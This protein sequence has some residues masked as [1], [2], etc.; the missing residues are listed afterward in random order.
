MASIAEALR[1]AAVTARE[2][3]IARF[4]EV[5]ATMAQTRTTMDI[6]VA[7][8]SALV[9]QLE[10]ERA[11]RETRLVSALESLD[12]KDKE[13]LEAAYMVKTAMERQ[14]VAERDLKRRTE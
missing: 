14:M 8:K 7:D 2:E 12:T 10:E 6:L 9:M 4:R 3:P 1:V 11:S 5:E 13:V